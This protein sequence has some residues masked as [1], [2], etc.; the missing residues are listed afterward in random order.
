MSTVLLSVSVV[1][2][3]VGFLKMF[4]FSFSFIRL[5]KWNFVS[6]EDDTVVSLLSDDIAVLLLPIDAM[7]F[8]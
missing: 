7:K 4:I 3:I 1:V 5:A 6:L 8:C 2:G